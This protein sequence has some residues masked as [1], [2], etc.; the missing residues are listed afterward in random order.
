MANGCRC[1]AHVCSMG[2]ICDRLG[3]HAPKTTSRWLGLAGASS[4]TSPS[5][6]CLGDN[7]GYN[8]VAIMRH[9]RV[10]SQSIRECDRTG[11][12]CISIRP[13]PREDKRWLPA[14]VAKQRQILRVQVDVGVGG[15][16]GSFLAC[17]PVEPMWSVPAVAC[18]PSSE[19]PQ[20]LVVRETR[21]A[22]KRVPFLLRKSAARK[23]LCS[24]AQ[25][26]RCGYS[27]GRR[28]RRQRPIV[29]GSARRSHPGRRHCSE[30]LEGKG[31]HSACMP[32]DELPHARHMH[33][34]NADAKNRKLRCK[35]RVYTMFLGLVS[36]GYVVAMQ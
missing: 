35:G 2:T 23:M 28:R 36:R 18:V 14:S 33:Q 11:P 10:E 21:C 17:P 16:E 24:H 15:L 4:S 25:R 34:V 29:G 22:D 3:P 8:I 9:T 31:M 19:E 5:H 7:G 6:M 30:W 32:G 1:T 13:L 27:V 12:I 20:A 26:E